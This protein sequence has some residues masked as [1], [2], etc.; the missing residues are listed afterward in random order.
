MVNG[1]FIFLVG[2]T[3][4]LLPTDTNLIMALVF[5]NAVSSGVVGAFFRPAISAMVP[6]LVPRKDT[7]TANGL[8]FGTMQISSLVGQSL[9]GVL[10]VILGAPLLMLVNGVTF[11]LSA[12]S[13][14]YII[15][16]HKKK[17]VTISYKKQIKNL[18]DEMV[19]GFRY[20]GHNVGLRN[21]LVM[22]A[23]RNFFVAPIGILLPFFV[24]DILHST[25]EWYGFL[26]TGMSAGVLLGYSLP[27]IM[28]LTPRHRGKWVVIALFILGFSV[29][30]FGYS[31]NMMV[32]LCMMVIH[33]TCMGFTTALTISIVQLTTPNE[34]RGRVLGLL[35][36]AMIAVS[37]IALG[38][39]GVITDFLD[40]NVVII[41][42]VC[43][44]SVSIVSLYLLFSARFH[45]LLSYEEDDNSV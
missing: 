12:F 14:S 26:M 23:V 8:L 39:T 42:L 2:V 13:E 15:V 19:D 40:Q 11:F 36:T 5:L 30:A 20:V 1:A 18:K 38:L 44:L 9:G 22:I 17:E 41:L 29:G 16:P 21:L 25:P 6:D 34:M 24:E 32:A 10:Y 28:N 45:V 4:F 31:S 37:P 35:T 43:G 27:G 33:G 3:M 7:I